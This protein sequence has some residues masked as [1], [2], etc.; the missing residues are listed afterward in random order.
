VTAVDSTT[1]LV[2]VTGAL[3][4]VTTLMAYATFRTAR[5]A[6]GEI[7][8]GRDVLDA[9]QRQADA[10]QRQVEVALMPMLSGVEVDESR[11]RQEIR[12]PDGQVVALSGATGVYIGKMDRAIL[13][14]VTLRN[15]GAGTA[16]VKGL[17][18]RFGSV[19]WPG[20]VSS[21]I[22]PPG[23]PSTFTFSLPDDRADVTEGDRRQL[24]QAS[25]SLEVG[26]TDA[27]GGQL[28]R[29]VAFL[30][31]PIND[32]GSARQRVRQIAL[33]KGNEQTP[34]VMSGPS[35]D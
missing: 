19:E 16:V 35:G 34:F 10:A 17:G 12:F 14:A 18:L 7:A 15:V 32:D 5:A 30:H 21:A 24:L 20:A 23:E 6:E 25:A 33:Y 26:Y 28:Y 27:H 2:W 13:C 8:Q 1:L 31:G 22:V 9:A 11:P 3:A 29:A 4:V